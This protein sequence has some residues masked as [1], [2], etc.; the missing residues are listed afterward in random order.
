MSSP[1]P[2]L[3]QGTLD[4]MVLSVLKAGT[5]H[6]YAIAR[7]I[8]RAS[9]GNLTIEEGSLYPALHRL[10]KRGDLDADWGKTETGRRARFYTLSRQGHKSL[11]E[12]ASLWQRVSSAVS[13]VLAAGERQQR[14]KRTAEH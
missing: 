10:S 11:F 12:Q 7:Q 4:V 3:L 2:E 9:G 1:T 5:L 6:G 13:G 14:L 8:E